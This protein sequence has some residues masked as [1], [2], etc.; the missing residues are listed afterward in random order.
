MR[1][2][3]GNSVVI[4]KQQVNVTFDVHNAERFLWLTRKFKLQDILEIEH[5]SNKF[6]I[7]DTYRMQFGGHASKEEYIASK[8][9][10][11]NGL[12]PTAGHIVLPETARLVM[13][14]NV[15][16]SRFFENFLGAAFNETSLLLFEFRP[17]FRTIDDDKF[18]RVL[19]RTLNQQETH[20]TIRIP[21]I[22]AEAQKQVDLEIVLTK[23]FGWTFARLAAIEYDGTRFEHYVEKHDGRNIYQANSKHV[24][25]ILDNSPIVIERTWHLYMAER[26]LGRFFDLVDFRPVYLFINDAMALWLRFRMVGTNFVNETFN[27]RFEILEPD[28]TIF[29]E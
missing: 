26:L 24:K 20:Q 8:K 10:F 14:S 21:L 22:D 17:F 27:V 29:L 12:R 18:E 16:M 13:K 3:L 2:N 19:R 6:L 7:F 25:R 5:D 9:R 15:T 11:M 28:Y 23:L 1:K 4:P